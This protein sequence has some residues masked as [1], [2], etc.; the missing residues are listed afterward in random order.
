MKFQELFRL[1]ILKEYKLI[2]ILLVYY[3]GMGFNK[4]AK[5]SSIYFETLELFSESLAQSIL[6]SYC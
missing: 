4:K 6:N 1:L 2:F 5:V 3:Q